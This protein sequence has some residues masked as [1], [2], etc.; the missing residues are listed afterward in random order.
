MLRRADN[1]PPLVLMVEDR[2]DARSELTEILE[3]NGCRVIETDNGQD[4]VK[5]ALFARPDLLLVDLNVPLLYGMM[6]GRQIVKHARLG[7]LPVVIA[8]HDDLV[9]TPAIMELGVRRNEYVTRL[10]DSQQLECL[11]NYL[12]TVNPQAA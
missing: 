6:A 12:L 2:P 4:A 10:S 3:R 7:N 8:A 1:A 5:R 11:L 9:D